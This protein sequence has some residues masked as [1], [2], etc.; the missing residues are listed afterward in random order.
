[1]TAAHQGQASATVVWHDSVG[2]TNDLA[3]EAADA[4]AAEGSWVLARR[5][6]GGRGR[7]G[8][9]WS[10]PAGNFYGSLLL[11]PRCSLADAASLSLVAGLA[12]ARGIGRATGGAVA[13]RLK[14]PNDVLVGGAKL[15]GILLESVGRD[16]LGPPCIIV[17]IGVNL[18]HAPDLTSYRT[19]SL[20]RLGHS[21]ILP[22]HFFESV[23]PMLQECLSV[24]RA[25]GFAAL[26]QA[27]LEIAHGIGSEV[28]L[29]LGSGERRGLLADLA[30]DGSILLEN[31]TGCLERFT[32]G[33]LFFAAP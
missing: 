14:W 30:A 2:S 27:W 33:E 25:G 31:S 20:A 6:T 15:A 23:E 10:S 3:R 7:H 5:Q 24:W 18:A 12:V 8:R 4:G 19:T 9:R 29:R 21:G 1:V 11:R 22:E 13:P 32:A 17:G 28:T 16:P 26:R